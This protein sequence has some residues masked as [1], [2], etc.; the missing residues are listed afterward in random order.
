MSRALA[1]AAAAAAAATRLIADC[2]L[3]SFASSR[4]CLTREKQPSQDKR[5][6]STSNLESKMVNVVKRERDEP[7]P[8]AFNSDGTQV[9][10]GSERLGKRSRRAASA[11]A[12][13]KISAVISFEENEEEEKQEQKK[14][15]YESPSS[16]S[17]SSVASVE[18][19]GDEEVIPARKPAT[20]GHNSRATFRKSEVKVT[21]GGNSSSIG[22]LSSEAEL[23]S[24]AIPDGIDV[25]DLPTNWRDIVKT[26]L[27]ACGVGADE[28]YESQLAAYDSSDDEAGDPPRREPVRKRL[29]IVEAAKHYKIPH[30]KARMLINIVDANLANVGLEV[31]CGKR[32]SAHRWTTADD[33]LLFAAVR[34]R[35]SAEDFPDRSGRT[36]LPNGFW[37]QLKL[38]NFPDRTES[39]LYQRW[40]ELHG[41]I[42]IQSEGPKYKWTPKEDADLFQ[43]VENER[44]KRINHDIRPGFWSALQKETFHWRSIDA[45]KKRLEAIEKRRGDK[46]AIFTSKDDDDILR[47][48]SKELE[49]SPSGNVRKDFWRR[50]QQIRFRDKTPRDLSDRYRKV[51]HEKKYGRDTFGCRFTGQEDA[52][53]KSLVTSRVEDNGMG[54]APSGL[55][56]DIQKHFPGR[57][58]RQLTDRWSWKKK[59]MRKAKAKFP[60][61]AT[62]THCGD[63]VKGSPKIATLPPY[64]AL[65]T[66]YPPGTSIIYCPSSSDSAGTARPG[67]VM[68]VEMRTSTHESGNGVDSL[69]LYTIFDDD[70]GN[71]YERVPERFLKKRD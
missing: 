8:S 14:D 4:L 69:Y 34:E 47:A 33:D 50:F 48:V 64:E 1:A 63:T 6:Q 36:R 41:S 7:S 45:L 27:A 61:A 62:T 10:D 59:Q 17:A 52:K 55:W 49:E 32:G 21:T 5:S 3:S 16:S 60:K 44:S 20:A 56:D 71:R 18:S 2:L 66:K 25:M 51:V 46:C 42:N 40:K 22:K 54:K 23:K 58:P 43:A 26:E 28:K 38:N 70:N 30:I 12:A 37:R 11:K 35:M 31:G 57:S 9:T 29:A 13:A 53:L 39:A 68:K 24:L 19:N 67:R 15:G 65:Q